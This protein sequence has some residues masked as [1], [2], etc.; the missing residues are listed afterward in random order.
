MIKVFIAKAVGNDVEFTLISYKPYRKP[1]SL[2]LY[3]AQILSWAT[4]T[5][6]P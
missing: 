6:S 2:Q 5:K 1:Q 4:L 3:S